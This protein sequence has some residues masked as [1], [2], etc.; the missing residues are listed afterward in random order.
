MRISDWSS[1]VCSSD[2]QRVGRL[3]EEQETEFAAL[4]EQQ[5]EAERGLPALAERLDD[6]RQHGDLYRHQPKRQ[7]E[8][9]QRTLQYRTHIE[10]HADRKEEESEQDQAKGFDVGLDL[11]PIGRIGEHHPGD[12]SAERGREMQAMHQ[13]RARADGQPSDDDEQFALAI[14]ARSE[15]RRVGNEGVSPSSTRWPPYH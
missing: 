7:R 1:D 13:G 14:A 5:A 6:Q 4:A 10:H 11:V 9:E 8:D 15:E 2:L 12:E 3:R